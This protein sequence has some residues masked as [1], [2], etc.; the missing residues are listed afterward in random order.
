M[1]HAR[2]RRLIPGRPPG[3]PQ[4]PPGGRSEGEAPGGA[5]PGGAAHGGPGRGTR[6]RRSRAKGHPEQAKG[7]ER[8]PQRR[9]GRPGDRKPITPQPRPLHSADG[10]RAARRPRRGAARTRATGGD[11]ARQ[12]KAGRA[13]VPRQR[14]P[15]PGPGRTRAQGRGRPGAGAGMGP[16]IPRLF[17]PWPKRRPRVG[18]EGLSEPASGPSAPGPQGRAL[19]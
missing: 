7:E 11:P 14:R 12:A 19:R 6:R 18:A 3:R 4:P 9:A 5:A 16:R 10:A 8:S 2:G 1:S 13:G 17:W 15:Q